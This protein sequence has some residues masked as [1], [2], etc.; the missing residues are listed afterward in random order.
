M[1]FM[2]IFALLWVSSQPGLAW[3]AIQTTRYSLQWAKMLIISIHQERVVVEDAIRLLNAATFV[4]VSITLYSA[5]CV[6]HSDTVAG[7][8]VFAY[9]VAT[10]AYLL[11]ETRGTVE[12]LRERKQWIAAQRMI[13]LLPG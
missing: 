6:W 12:L 7:R 5:V 4:A 1:F 13:N 3:H 10:A 9:A 2:L 11:T 8:M